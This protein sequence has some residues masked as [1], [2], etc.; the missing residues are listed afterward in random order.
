MTNFSSSLRRNKKKPTNNKGFL[1]IEFY[2]G[3]EMISLSELRRRYVLHVL[4]LAKNFS[5]ACRQIIASDRTLREFC[6]KNN[7][8]C[9]RFDRPMVSTEQPSQDAIVFTARHEVIPMRELKRRYIEHVINRTPTIGIALATLK[10]SD[11]GLR[12]FCARHSIEI[13]DKR[14]AGKP[15]SDFSTPSGIRRNCEFDYVT[16][17]ERDYALNLDHPNGTFRGVISHKLPL[18]PSLD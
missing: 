12:E 7:I 17:K 2:P 15:P 14:R 16:P 8:S 1:I 11:R 18:D 13:K 6:H 4:S 9:S 10:M 5:E 3:Q